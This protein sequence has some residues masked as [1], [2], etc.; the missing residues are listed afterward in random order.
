MQE[1]RKEREKQFDMRS[2]DH[3]YHFLGCW[4]LQAW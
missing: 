1:K 4:K 3:S 2:T